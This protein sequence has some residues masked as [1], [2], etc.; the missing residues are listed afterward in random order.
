MANNV[1]V[2]VRVRP[3]SQREL[4]NHAELI[5]DM[6]G[7]TTLLTNPKKP[8]ADPQRF[9]FDH[10]YWSHDEY[11]ETS[12][13]YLEPTSTTSKYT[14]QLT[15]YKDL[16]QDM[17]INAWDGYNCSIFAYGQTGSGKSYSIMG[18]GAN[19]GIVPQIVQN[20]FKDI[21]SK[22]N[23][24]IEH[25]V[26]FSMLEIYNERVKDLLSKK[27]APAAGL[28][29]RQSPEKGFYVVNL[30]EVPVGGFDEVKSRMDEGNK[31]RTIGR[32][33]MNETSSRA[34]TIVCINFKQNRI[35]EKVTKYCSINLVDLAGS[36][37][38]RQTQAEGQRFKESRSIN[39]S[40]STLGRVIEDLVQKKRHIPFND[41]VL[42]KLLKNALEG[43][44]KTTMIAT[45]SPDSENYNQTLSTL[46]YADR[47]KSIKTTAVVNES[48]T[49]KLVKDLKHEKEILLQ[50]LSNMK[51]ARSYERQGYS[52]EDIQ[53]IRGEIEAD[54]NS[55]ISDL[56]KSWS[57]RLEQARKDL[58]EQIREQK[59]E[60][61]DIT[62]W[63][64][65]W[66]LNEDPALCGKIIHFLKSE[67]ELIG[68]GKGQ[69]SVTICINGPNIVENHAF[70]FNRE[71]SVFLVPDEGQVLR[72]GSKLDASSEVKLF[73]Q[74]R[75]CFG[76]KTLY[77][78][79]SP[80]EAAKSRF[81]DNVLTSISF[82]TAYSEMKQNSG[83]DPYEYIADEPFNID[84]QRLDPDGI[85]EDVN[86]DEECSENASKIQSD[87]TFML[88]ETNLETTTPKDALNM[89]FSSN[90][91]TDLDEVL[92][93]DPDEAFSLDGQQLKLKGQFKPDIACDDDKYMIKVSNLKPTTHYDTLS[94]FFESEEKTGAVAEK[95]EYEGGSGMAFITYGEN[96]DLD[97]VL[98]KNADEPFSIDG[99]QV[100]LSKAKLKPH[101]Q[102][103]DDKYMI[104]VSNLKPTTHY[105]NLSLFFESKKKTGAVAEKVEYEDGSGI[106]F[107]TYSGN[108]D[109][110]VVMRKHADDPF[111]LE[112][113][114]LELDKVSNLKPTT[115]YDNLSLFF[116]SK[117]KTGAVAE[118]VEYEDGSGIA[119]VTYSG[120][121]DL[122]VVMRKHADD[123]F[124]LESQHLE[125]DKV[126]QKSYSQCDDDKYMIKVSNLKPT[127]HY[128]NLSLFFESKKKTGAIAENVEYEDGSGMA[129]ITYGENTDLD[130]VVKKHANVPFNLEG[131]QLKLDKVQSK[132]R[133]QCDDDKYMIKVSNL[134]PT[135]HYDNLSLFFE[136]KK[137]TGAVAEKVEYEDGSGIAFVTYSGNTDLDEVLKKNADEPF[138]IDGQ[139][140][141]LRKAK[142]KPDI[143]CNDD[144]YMIKVSNLKPTTHYDNL[145]L[146]FESK[147][148]TG[149]VADK[150]EYENG[151]GIAFVTYSGNTDLDVVMRKHADD[152]FSLESQQLELDKVQQKSYSQCDDDKYM[153]KVSNLKPTTHYDNLSLFFE[154]KQKTGAVAEKVEYED[155]SGIAFVTYSGNTD[156]DVVMRKHADDPFSLESQQLELDKVQQKSYS[157]CDD[158]KYMIKVSNLKPTTH[159]DNLSL[160]F[161][162]KKKTGAVAEKVEY[163][164]GS[165][166]AFVTYS[167]N[168]DLDVVMRKHADDPFSLESQQL[169]LDKVQ[170]KSYSQ[171]DDDKY[172]IKV[173]NLK[174]TTHY[175]NL[176]LFFESKKKTGA[177]ADKVE[178]ENG[179]G[180]AFVTYSG[181]TDLDVVMRKHADD[182]FSLESQQLELDKVQQKSYSQCDDDKYMIKVSNLKPTTHYDNLSLFFESKKKTGAVAEKVEYENGSGMAF[183]TYGETT[184]LD[185]A[186]KKYANVPFSLDGQQLELSKVAPKPDKECDDDIYYDTVSTAADKVECEDASG[187]ASKTHD[188]K[189]G[190]ETDEDEDMLESDS[191]LDTEYQ[192]A[193]QK[194]TNRSGH[195][196]SDK[197]RVN[198]G[199]GMDKRSCIV[200]GK[201]SFY[202]ISAIR[203]G[204]KW[205]EPRYD[206]G[207][208]VESYEIKLKGANEKSW[209]SLNHVVKQSTPGRQIEM[210]NVKLQ[211]KNP[212]FVKI[213]AKYQDNTTSDYSEI[214]DMF[215]IEATGEDVFKAKI[216]E[217]CFT[218]AEDKKP[219]VYQMNLT[220]T[221]GEKDGSIFKYEY[222][223][224]NPKMTN[225]V[226]LVVGATGAGKSTLI[227]GLINYIFGVTWDDS[228]RLKLIAEPHASKQ[229]VSQTRLITAYTLHYETG[230]RV[231]YTITIID[232]PGFGDT[233]GYSR[234]EEITGQIRELFTKF[235][236][237]V[238]DHIDAVGFVTQSSLPRLTPTQ[239]YIF[240]KIL[241][242]FGKDIGDNILMMLTFADAQEP[243]VLS[244]IEEAGFK[245]KKCFKFNNSA[246]FAEKKGVE[247]VEMFNKM[248]WNMGEE[249]FKLFF[250]YLVRCQPRSLT[251]TKE[252]L[253]ER[254]R[255]ELYMG[256]LQQDISEGLS[257]LESL[258]KEVQVII[259]NQALIDANK[260]FD[261]T[262]DEEH[263]VREDIPNGKYVTNCLQCNF[264]CHYPCILSDD[265]DKY[266]CGAMMDTKGPNAVCAFCPKR[267]SWKLH[268]NMP[269]R[270]VIQIETVQKT[271]QNLKERYQEGVEGKMTA[272]NLK[273]QVKNDFKKHQLMMYMRTEAARKTLKRL[274]EIALK[275]NAITT[276]DYI[277]TLIE[278][279]R[280]EHQP[281][282]EKRIAHLRKLR[283]QTEMFDK[284]VKNGKNP[285][286]EHI[287]LII[288]SEEKK[289][290]DGYKERIKEWEEM[291]EKV[292]TD[293]DLSELLHDM[294]ELE[295]ISVPQKGMSSIWSALKK[296]GNFLVPQKFA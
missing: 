219:A 153:I 6:Q 81:Q 180:I 53:R 91:K 46:R 11:E 13:G 70:I 89:P 256:G 168:T 69:T 30:R 140:V 21:A 225:K 142:L 216:L 150:V 253:E 124:S 192:S 182:P 279:E 87:E 238:I 65:L 151:S 218:S 262:V 228:Y 75:I 237:E 205:S 271:S 119:F 179:S 294:P 98:R 226:V 77:V 232:T 32:T 117:K 80:D 114:Q 255:L 115:H 160:F 244:G 213:A 163:E 268:K 93:K 250:D 261:Y 187:I 274:N 59:K 196:I 45:I 126:Q 281:G 257:H 227:N 90:E 19:K 222:G 149:A 247:S 131:Q 229:A 25:Q 201:P 266:N 99:Q 173:S 4:D 154:S 15:M 293:T 241:S 242:L 44:S 3:F 252:V 133:I 9:T 233:G 63:P 68:N 111:S 49:S 109:L 12:S 8:K 169:E 55:S 175:D 183:I 110:D 57:E 36:E 184:D 208:S 236:T 209:K 200:P 239:R 82:D 18:Y 10:S 152:P 157:Q 212:Y 26:T 145:S 284:T 214:S 291:K 2:A 139:Q 230:S 167:G 67:K 185:E 285:F 286:A 251:L 1:K 5:I 224:R 130:K 104:K 122:D 231:P 95:V 276:V 137:K 58:E 161:E 64:H 282:Y 204:I 221:Y 292:S 92:K 158:D 288:I 248:F 94:M 107:V 43:N 220:K 258:T 73:H 240:D 186:L 105:D 273:H 198:V 118:K 86:S 76:I 174:P 189:T 52:E 217:T 108:T 29:I 96:T 193:L 259:K 129:F 202:K 84:I 155:G 176:S 143:Q 280:S 61:E 172:M 181:N 178:Y 246:V 20:L 40:L 269:Y 191:D 34:H 206:Q 290:H 146:F 245:Y 264:T 141:E 103:Y 41:S 287:D 123:P 188:E 170:Q 72:N 211:A 235:G 38:Q 101:I 148:K 243:Q 78:F 37:N 106:A 51:S 112:S 272:D 144:K 128:D 60:E 190:L 296:F 17:L 162:S 14:D 42:T 277:D 278:A 50:E 88:E 97:E 47:A 35:H 7:P 295:G 121:T 289:K 254:H 31:N 171:C 23:K 22:E 28:R 116:E 85:E 234:D 164:D 177:V 260:D 71:G 74:D 125:L 166:I 199:N 165:G 39:L 66:N 135:T 100:E 27:K 156:L 33:K 275:P 16:G 56:E 127:T 102:C 54:L 147:K 197:M 195:Y 134:K 120:N 263:T 283:K 207:M 223:K 136:S 24:D 210:Q 138:S 62:K 159:Y 249:S 83:I 267:C 113:Q 270:L 215:T 194:K 79:H 48:E 203:A 265:D 132:P